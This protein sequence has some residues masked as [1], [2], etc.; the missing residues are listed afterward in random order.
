MFSSENADKSWYPLLKESREVLESIYNAV[1]AEGFL[2]DEG[3]VLRFLTVP[4]PAVRVVILGQDPYPQP[5]AATGRSFEVGGL[6]DWTKPF[7]QSSLRNFVRAIYGAY[8][9]EIPAWNAVRARI[10]DGSFPLAPPDKLWDAL[11]AQG[12]LFLNAY[13]TVAPGKPGAH[14]ALWLPFAHALVR[15]ID[16]NAPDAA[17]FLW[18]SD[19]KSFACDI[20]SGR[21]YESRHPMLTGPWPDDFLKNPCFRETK[22]RINWL[23]K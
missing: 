16:A 12:V 23:G 5:G 7:R 3:R 9:G 21:R 14:R 8:H 1:S 19:A 18:G 11:E 2:P 17:W 4:L 15:Y 10:A 22:D 13:L 20:H 6:S